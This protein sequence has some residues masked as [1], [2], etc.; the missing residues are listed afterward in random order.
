MGVP[1]V[2]LDIRRNH[3]GGIAMIQPIDHQQVI[4]ILTSR[5]FPS[6]AVVPLTTWADYEGGT[7]RYNPLNTTL[8]MMGST[9]YNDV[10]V[11]NYI[12]ATQGADAIYRTLTNGLY[13]YVVTALS[14]GWPLEL[15]NLPEIIAEINT[16][17]THGFAKYIQSLGG[18]DMA[19][20]AYKDDNDARREKV[21]QIYAEVLC[22][23]IE[24]EQAMQTWV[25]LMASSGADAVRAA[26]EDSDEGKT[27]TAAKRRVLGL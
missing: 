12:S 23:E 19:G 7:A 13:D 25:N 11:Q 16:W 27:V 9:N 24:S 26:L 20:N 5:N 1:L 2:E 14:N 18:N 6:S 21:R 10:G 15:W 3:A 4:S 22:R 17:G 8:R